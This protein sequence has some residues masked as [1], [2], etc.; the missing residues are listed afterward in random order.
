MDEKSPF[1]NFKKDGWTNYEKLF[2]GWKNQKIIFEASPGY[3]YSKLAAEKLGSIPDIKVIIIYRNPVDRIFSEYQFTRYKTKN[4]T[5]SYA[6]YL[7]FDGTNFKSPQF[8]KTKLSPYLKQWMLYLKEH[9]LKIIP[10]EEIKKN[11]KSVMRKIAEF[12]EIDNEFYESFAFEKKNETFGLRNRKTHK[13][14]LKL[15]KHV[16]E[17]IQRLLIPIYYYFN[18]TKIPPISQEEHHINKVLSEC[19][20]KEKAD[21]L[22]RYESFFI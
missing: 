18:R 21:F 1:P 12:L 6:E 2:E 5:G 9:Q 16:P 7:G 20:E 14:L 19:L 10:F 4:F 11:P 13:H 8:E 3:I 15:K 17:F 22:S